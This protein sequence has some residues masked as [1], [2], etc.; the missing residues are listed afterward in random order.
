M[1]D[2]ENHFLTADE[3]LKAVRIA[4]AQYPAQLNLLSLIWPMVFGKDAYLLHDRQ[5]DVTWAKIPGRKKLAS[6][7]EPALKQAILDWLDAQPPTL[8]TLADI[9][10]HIFGAMVTDDPAPVNGDPPGV[11]IETDMTGFVCRQCG[12]CCRM[13]G[14]RDGCSVADY[15]RWQAL[16]RD[17]IL[18]WVDP[19]YQD[20][21]LI[22]CRIW[23][24][25][26]THRYAETCPWLKPADR[27][28][29]T[30]CAIYD[31]R[32]MV[33]RHYPGTRKHGRLTGCLAV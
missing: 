13:L 1:T 12:H 14:Y 30:I 17:D 29:Q 26:G 21:V 2:K 4:F 20:D 28:G 32:P 31:L 25:P 3:A 22:D 23:I 18:A 33:C 6:A 16:G 24:Q 11:W 5:K 8:D 19:H 15:R 9:C 10:S 27:P 7:T